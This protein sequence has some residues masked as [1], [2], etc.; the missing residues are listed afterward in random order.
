MTTLEVRMYPTYDQL[1]FTTQTFESA[2]T[3]YIMM[4][5][6]DY[7][8]DQWLVNH[9]SFVKAEVLLNGAVQ[10]TLEIH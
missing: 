2:D 8:R 4:K 7:I 10:A 1:D 6:L 5:A 9:F 3:H